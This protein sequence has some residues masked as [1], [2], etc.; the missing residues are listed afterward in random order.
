VGNRPPPTPPSLTG[1]GKEKTPPL[2]KGRLGGIL[3]VFKYIFR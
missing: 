3:V 1:R 2:T